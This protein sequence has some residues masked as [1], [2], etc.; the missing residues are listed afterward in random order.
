M[1]NQTDGPAMVRVIMNTTEC[2]SKSTMGVLRSE[3]SIDR[4]FYE[5]E[6]VGCLSS[7]YF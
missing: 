2:Q 4:C 3:R 5:K 1:E 7:F 6:Y